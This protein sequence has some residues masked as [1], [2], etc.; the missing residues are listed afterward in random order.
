VYL[1]EQII[2]SSEQLANLRPQR[3]HFSFVSNI[4][5]AFVCSDMLAPSNCACPKSL[6]IEAL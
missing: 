3:S 5:H 2:A 6:G 1:N 4:V